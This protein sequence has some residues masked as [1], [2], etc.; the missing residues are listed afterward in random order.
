MRYLL[1]CLFLFLPLPALSQELP[2]P[3]SDTVSDFANILT[4]EEEARIAA[5]LTEGRATTGAHVVVATMARIADHGGAGERIED[6]AKRLFNLW[7]IGDADRDDGI[8]ILVAKDDRE[9]RI[10]LGAG[11]EVIWD[12]AAQRVIN[13]DLLPAFRE[14][15]Y[16][17]GIEAAV[18]GVYETIVK[19]H[20]AGQ[21]APTPE[22]SNPMDILMLIFVAVFAVLAVIG[23]WSAS[24]LG[25]FDRFR[26]CSSCGKRTLDHVRHVV[27]EPTQTV[28]GAGERRESC[29]SCGM[30]H[31]VPYDIMHL[32]A[33][34]ISDDGNSGGFGGGSSSGGGASGRW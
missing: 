30:V 25:A 7:G 22:Q 19:P 5:A 18:S 17:Q 11:Y 9:V 2:Q 6:Y 8:L 27:V 34:S 4:P 1:V 12:N 20:Q 28:K 13:R 32:R 29:R 26:K 16:P 31:V 21:P 14:D 33:H 10:A 23:G 15:R 24:I 3:L